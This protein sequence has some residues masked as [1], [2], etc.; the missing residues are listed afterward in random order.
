MKFHVRLSLTSTAGVDDWS[1][2]T[3]LLGASHGYLS[4]LCRARPDRVV[5]LRI[6]GC[7]RLGIRDFGAAAAV[8]AARPVANIAARSCAATAKSNKS[9]DVLFRDR[10]RIRSV[11]WGACGGC[12]ADTAQAPWRHHWRLALAAVHGGPIGMARGSGDPVRD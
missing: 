7:R 8:N 5:A 6:D 9:V 11:G 3:L 12:R 10:N 4:L 1:F 2:P